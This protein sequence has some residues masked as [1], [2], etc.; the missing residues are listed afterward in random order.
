MKPLVVIN[1]RVHADAIELLLSLCD[2]AL[3]TTRTACPRQELK[4]LARN[5]HALLA[6]AP[7]RIDESLLVGCHRLRIVA[8]TFRI[9]K[10]IDVGACTRRG[11]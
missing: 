8:C 9:A 2:V 1:H 6:A 11:I 5:A 4:Q 3:V 7:E 10:H